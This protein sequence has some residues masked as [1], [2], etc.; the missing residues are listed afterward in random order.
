MSV[1]PV[2][3]E[4]SGCSWVPLGL[5]QS[6]PNL[7]PHPFI[8]FW[9]TSWLSLS[10][11]LWIRGNNWSDCQVL[12][13]DENDVTLLLPHGLF[14]SVFF[15]LRLCHSSTVCSLWRRLCHSKGLHLLRLHGCKAAVWQYAVSYRRWF[16][17]LLCCVLLI[18]SSHFTP[19]NE[20]FLFL[21]L[22]ETVFC[23]TPLFVVCPSITFTLHQLSHVCFSISSHLLSCFWF[24]SINLW[25]N[26]LNALQSFV[27]HVKISLHIYPLISSRLPV[28]AADTWLL[29]S[30]LSQHSVHLHI[31]SS[32]CS[33]VLLEPV[34]TNI[35]Y[36]LASFKIDLQH[37]TDS[38]PHTT[39]CL[40]LHFA[41]KKPTSR[42]DV[43]EMMRGLYNRWC[44][45]VR[46]NSGCSP[47]QQTT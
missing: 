9:E 20:M 16:I 25:A 13:S 32:Y 2:L 22:S 33:A 23:F 14:L 35:L 12:C 38:G 7:P 30:T 8:V 19:H 44:H 47:W 45:T 34:D 10:H 26:S 4:D 18:W 21:F 15:L 11:T 5:W 1:L 42:C 24:F 39:K 31:C 46:C 28:N 40:M 29:P 43:T 6:R 27:L 37:E 17:S 3:A 36:W 41:V